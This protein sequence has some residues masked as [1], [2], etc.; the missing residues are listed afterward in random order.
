M[1]SRLMRAGMTVL[2]HCH[3]RMSL[4]GIHEV[5]PYTDFLLKRRIDFVAKGVLRYA[6][7]RIRANS[8]SPLHSLLKDIRAS[9][10]ICPI[11]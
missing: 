8:R 1:D 3:T 6:L 4:L 5:C 2:F 10:Q 9:L 11:S 7:C